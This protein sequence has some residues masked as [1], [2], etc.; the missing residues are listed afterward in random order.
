MRRRE[1]IGTKVSITD[2]DEVL[3]AID[4]AVAGN[5]PSYI[6][7][8]PA[9]SLVFARDDIPLANALAAADVVTPDGMGVVHAARLLGEKIETRVYGPD[10]MDM[11]LARAAAAATPTYLYGG[12]D[13]AALTA[14][15]EALVARHPGLNIA[16]S[17]SPPHRELTTDE[18]SAA[19]DA[20][21]AS[22]ARIVWVGLGS[23]KQEVWMHENRAV[24]EAPV[25]V[26]VGAA[27]DFFAG[28]V[29]QA[30]RWMQRASLEWLYRMFQ[31]PARL[32]KRYLLTLPRFAALAF[33]QAFR[34]RILR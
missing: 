31:D 10:L 4:T 8:T 15:R 11:Q 1:I 30:P 9:S 14:L 32:G 34:E 27:F 20:I 3:D 12:H 22:G 29:A 5:T 25:L 26:G 19:C 28:R 33:A 2:Y 7:C 17:Y 21:N 13:D 18:L 6:C 16:G 24:L 23:P